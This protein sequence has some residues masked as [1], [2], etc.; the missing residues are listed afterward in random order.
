MVAATSVALKPT[1][2]I[3]TKKTNFISFNE[4][5]INW[6]TFVNEPIQVAFIFFLMQHFYTFAS[7]RWLSLIFFI[8]K[9]YRSRSQFVECVHCDNCKHSRQLKRIKRFG[10]NKA[11]LKCDSSVFFPFLFSSILP[12]PPYFSDKNTNR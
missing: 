4:K 9:K 10:N 1:K 11:S 6:K 2:M 3:K 8:W 12:M 7:S 5:K